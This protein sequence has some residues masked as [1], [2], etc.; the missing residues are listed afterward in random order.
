[1]DFTDANTGASAADYTA[2]VALGD[3]TT[4]S[5][6]STPSKYGRIVSDGDG[7]FDVQLSYMYT[8]QLSNATF[9]VKVTADDG[10]TTGGSKTFNVAAAG[11]GA[12]STASTIVPWGGSSSG[13]VLATFGDTDTNAA[14]ANYTVTWSNGQVATGTASYNSSVNGFQVT[15][16]PPASDGNYSAAIAI[17]DSDGNMATATAS[18]EVSSDFYYD[19]AAAGTNGWNTT[20][21]EWW[22][23]DANTIDKSQL[24]TWING[25]DA[26]FPTTAN[27]PVAI[28]I[29]TSV[30][31]NSLTVQQGGNY[32]FSGSRLS[33]CPTG[34]AVDVE[35]TLQLG[36]DNM[37]PAASAVSIGASGQFDL[38]SF[39]QTIGSLTGP[40]GAQV[41]DSTN[42]GASVLTVD[43][44]GG[45]TTY[46]GAIGVG[47]VAS[48]S[49]GLTLSANNTFSGNV[50]VFGGT[51]DLSGSDTFAGSILVAGGTLDLSTTN[52]PNTC[53]GGT[54]VMGGTLETA[55]SGTLPGWSTPGAVTVGNGGTLELDV[56]SSWMVPGWRTGDIA[57]LLSENGGGFG[58]GSILALNTSDPSN[59]G[60]FTYNGTISGEMGLAKLGVNTLELTA[61][62]NFAGPAEIDDGTVD[63]DQDGSLGTG[64]LIINGGTLAYTSVGS[65]TLS[66]NLT[67]ALGP[68]ACIT[69]TH[70]ISTLTIDSHISDAGATPGGLTTTGYG[71]LVLDGDNTYTGSTQIDTGT[72]SIGN[73]CNLGAGPATATADQLVI[74]NG[75]LKVTGAVTLGADWGVAIGP[76]A[77]VDVVSAGDNLILQRGL[78]MAPG[79]T[80][81]SLTTTARANSRW[82]PPPTPPLRK[83]RSTSTAARWSP[84]APAQLGQLPNVVVSSGATLDLGD[85][86]A[87]GSLNG[88][89]AVNTDG[90]VLTV[91]GAN[92]LDSSFSGQ[93]L[94]NSDGVKNGETYY[95][96]GLVKAGSGTFTLSNASNNSNFEGTTE[97]DGGVLSI[98][99]GTNLGS[100]PL[101]IN[102]GT[103]EATGPTT[104]DSALA[105]AIGSGATINVDSGDTL[106]CN[107]VIANV[108]SAAG[109]LTKIGAEY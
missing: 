2:S 95:Y 68:N 34:T 70:L 50:S 12:T 65:L 20:T 42:S 108:D 67:L 71:T 53:T 5:L 13:M 3:G 87:V 61:T 75:T 49:G 1:M 79:A 19:A 29:G 16:T 48:G 106:T 88:G 47:L 28:V 44:T 86:T 10:A 57:T 74:D 25:G 6:T 36:A 35:G 58:A 59:D 21:Q 92:N 52:G 33:A 66:D 11:M 97:I 83:C 72:L 30:A 109:G 9:A 77:S 22:L 102:G 93:L 62:N 73:V 41:V 103:L 56:V 24:Y 78:E 54:F 100:G 26:I 76:S 69:V 107:G 32:S 14:T 98:S 46:A 55:W 27:A 63:I 17:S 96:D 89:G 18:V 80:S 31:A 99:S 101:T 90:C 82:K 23:G 7:G 104:L 84:D 60:G 43:M 15:G 51:L 45:N 4:A 94:G 91:G 39:S 64:A 105:I 40:A 85:N 8:K 81:C 37:L 38:D